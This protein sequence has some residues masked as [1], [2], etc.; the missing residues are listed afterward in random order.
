MTDSFLYLLSSHYI[1]KGL[2]IYWLFTKCSELLL[3]EGRKSGPFFNTQ[4]EQALG[5]LFFMLIL[6]QLKR[7]GSP[8]SSFQ[9]PLLLPDEFGYFSQLLDRSQPH[10]LLR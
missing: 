1:I 6:I 7:L 5:L 4:K 8:A 9:E 10:Y 2:K 3:L